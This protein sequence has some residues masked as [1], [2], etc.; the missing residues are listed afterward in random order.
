[1][2]TAVILV[3]FSALSSYI[4]PMDSQKLK[5]KIKQDVDILLQVN[6]VI[7]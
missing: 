7:Y 2:S 5:E 1:M 4:V 3:S 6:L